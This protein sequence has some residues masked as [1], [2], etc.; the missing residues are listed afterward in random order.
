MTYGV[1]VPTEGQAEVVE[2]DSSLSSMR[3][4]IRGCIERVPMPVS[5]GKCSYLCDKGGRLGH[6]KLPKNDAISILANRTIYGTVL[7]LAP[8]TDDGIYAMDYESAERVCGAINDIINSKEAHE[9]ANRT[10]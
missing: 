1:K 3:R 7:I 6:K 8:L 4:I 5:G 2:C 10:V 9:N